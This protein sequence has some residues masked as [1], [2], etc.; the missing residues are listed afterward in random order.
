MYWLFYKNTYKE[1]IH[2]LC[3]KFTTYSKK[4]EKNNK[5]GKPNNY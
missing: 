5:H 2:N 1:Y 3:I 4:D